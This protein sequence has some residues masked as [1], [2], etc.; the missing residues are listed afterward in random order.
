MYTGHDVRLSTLGYYGLVYIF[1][2]L[3]PSDI[4]KLVLVAPYF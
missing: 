4:K 2:S 3:V 1:F